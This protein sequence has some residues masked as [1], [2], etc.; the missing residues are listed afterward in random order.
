LVLKYAFDGRYAS[1]ALKEIANLQLRPKPYDLAIDALDQIVDLYPD[2]LEVSYA[3][4]KTAENYRNLAKGEEYNQGGVVIARRYYQECVVI[5]PQ[6]SE[7]SFARKMIRDLEESVVRSEISLGGFY[8]H[9]RYKEKAAKESY[10]LAIDFK[11]YTLAVGLT[12]SK[13]EEI[14][15]GKKPRSTPADFLF[16]PYKLQNSNDFIAVATVADRIM[17]QNEG[18]INPV[19]KNIVMPFVK[20]DD[21]CVSAQGEG[22]GSR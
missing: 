8:F 20:W 22:G 10:L 13:I 4:L 17:D 14:N 7:V 15:R 2:S 11:P 12:Q 21:D 19:H 18:R 3:Y 9:S 6:H 5:F 1:H 16:L